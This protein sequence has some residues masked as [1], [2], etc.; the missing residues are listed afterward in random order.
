[1]PAVLSAVIRQRR[2]A[3]THF[4]STHAPYNKALMKYVYK[5]QGSIVSGMMESEQG[6]EHLS[7]EPSVLGVSLSIENAV[8]NNGLKQHIIDKPNTLICNWMEHSQWKN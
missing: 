5:R 3:E 8:T 7:Q 2:S 6:M 4:N 1:M